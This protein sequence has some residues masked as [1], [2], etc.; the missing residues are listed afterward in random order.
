MKQN[1]AGELLERFGEEKIRAAKKTISVITEIDGEKYV[2]VFD[3]TGGFIVVSMEGDAVDIRSSCDMAVM[4]QA[5]HML[6]QQVR[7]FDPT[8]LS[9]LAMKD[10]ADKIYLAKEVGRA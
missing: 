4:A 3:G 7:E 6:V 9:L 10:I 8:I 2:E 1:E 5:A